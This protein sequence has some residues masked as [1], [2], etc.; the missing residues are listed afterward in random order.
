MKGQFFFNGEKERMESIVL[1]LA[2]GHVAF[3]NN[4][5]MMS[6]PSVVDFCPFDSLSEETLIEFENTPLVTLL[7]EVGSRLM[8]R[9]ILT[10]GNGYQP[11]ITVQENRYRFVVFLDGPRTIVRIVI[12][13]Y[14]AC[15][16]IWE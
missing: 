1:K 7:P 10:H 6:E 8:Q 15:E 5:P 12:S 14:L 3:L 11:W 2:K 4:E 16:V 13:E 9:I